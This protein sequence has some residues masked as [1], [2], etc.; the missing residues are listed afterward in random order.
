MIDSP[1]GSIA[2]ASPLAPTMKRLAKGSV[3]EERS[4]RD[5]TTMAYIDDGTGRVSKKRELGE[6]RETGERGV[7]VLATTLYLGRMRTAPPYSPETRSERAWR[8]AR[9]ESHKKQI[10][11]TAE[12]TRAFI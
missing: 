3:T 11:L 5:G 12:S 8:F 1:D 2:I 9:T 6:S 7:C 10:E 4:A